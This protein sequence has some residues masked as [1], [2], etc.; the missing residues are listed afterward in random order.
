MQDVKSPNVLL[1]ADFTA[2]ISDVGLAKLQN[3]D[4]L[5]AQRQVGTFTWSVSVRSLIRPLGG[6]QRAPVS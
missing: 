6:L 2:K 3:K 5:S 4:Y 1:A